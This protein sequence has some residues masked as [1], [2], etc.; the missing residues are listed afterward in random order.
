M[1][2]PIVIKWYSSKLLEM[3]NICDMFLRE[4]HRSYSAMCNMWFDLYT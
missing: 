3:K 4:K 1:E 2:Y